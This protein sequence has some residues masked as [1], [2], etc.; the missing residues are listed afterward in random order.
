MY[1][2]G[3]NALNHGTK[4]S[5]MHDAAGIAIN[6]I[7]RKVSYFNNF[8]ILDIIVRSFVKFHRIGHHVSV[9]PVTFGPTFC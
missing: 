9:H 2:S 7:F 5:R 4:S 3:K 1:I 6:K 8:I